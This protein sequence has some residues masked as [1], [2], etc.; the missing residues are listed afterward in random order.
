[1]KFFFL[2]ITLNSSVITLCAQNIPS[3]ASRPQTPK[4]PFEY[5]SDSVEYDNADNTV[6]LAG[7]L[8]YPKTGGPFIAAVMITGSGL[9]DRDETVFGHH[10]FAVIADYLTKNGF[11]VLRVD[12]RTKGKSTGDVKNATSADFAEDVIT[13]L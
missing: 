12:D 2:L 8:S 1:M 13:S 4:P 3:A 10:P 9:Q 5:N 11:A 6:H 7:T